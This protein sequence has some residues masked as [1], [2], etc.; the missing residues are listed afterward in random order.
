MNHPF[1]FY[2][3][4]MGKDVNIQRDLDQKLGIS[5]WISN[6]CYGTLFWATGT[7]KSRGAL[8]TVDHIYSIKKNPK[9]LLVVPTRK[10]RD[11]NW[12]NEA[13]K[14]SKSEEYDKFDRSC[15]ASISKIE[16]K[17]Y[18]LV[19][20]DEAHHITENNNQF[21][22]NNKVAAVLGL[23][24]TE[25]QKKDK[26]DLLYAVAPKVHTITLEEAVKKG[27]VSPFKINVVGIPVS[28]N[29]N[30]F[31]VK[32][33]KV[34]FWQSEK[35]AYDFECKKI[36]K[37]VLQK[38]ELYESTQEEL[39]ELKINGKHKEIYEIEKNLAKKMESLNKQIKMLRLNRLRFL[40]NSIS[41][42]KIAKM[43]LD[44]FFDKDERLLIFAGSIKQANFLCEQAF[45]SKTKDHD[46]NA[47]NAGEIN[48]LS[49]VMSLNEG[50]NVEDLQTALVTQVTRQELVFIQRLG[51][52]VRYKEDR[53]ANIWILC[54]LDTVDEEWIEEALKSFNMDNIN[55]YSL[56]DIFDLIEVKED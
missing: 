43:M 47:F 55:F 18:D 14:W 32:N 13:I 2:F 5:N 10:L 27:Y 41:K 30:D 11:R 44:H 12:K 28:T 37:F 45:H 39:L 50:E 22:L 9:I 34:H 29:K 35:S 21:F 56:E 36:D 48:R 26:K 33:S 51:R 53:L 4:W 52:L 8:L 20:L 15:Y 16:G 25:P 42:Q 19:I 49:C 54:L 24:A 23:T 3:Y 38:K 40:Q 6:D 46:Y 17:E 7:G 31:E 1:I